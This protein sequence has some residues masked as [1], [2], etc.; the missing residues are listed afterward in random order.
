MLAQTK[1]RLCLLG[2]IGNARC[3]V[4]SSLDG[5]ICRSFAEN[6]LDLHTLNVIDVFAI[7]YSKL[8]SLSK[9]CLREAMLSTE[10]HMLAIKFPCPS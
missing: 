2:R 3:C 1:R 5:A 7:V 10:L 6:C 9:T 8:V 4:N